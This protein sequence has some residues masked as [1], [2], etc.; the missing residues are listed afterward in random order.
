MLILLD[1]DINLDV[2]E[3]FLFEG[4]YGPEEQGK[5]DV[6]TLSRWTALDLLVEVPRLLGEKALIMGA[7]VDRDKGIWKL[8]GTLYRASIFRSNNLSAISYNSASTKDAITN[9]LKNKDYDR[10]GSPIAFVQCSDF[11]NEI[12]QKI[13]TP[14]AYLRLEQI[15]FINI[16]KTFQNPEELISSPAPPQTIEVINSLSFDENNV[17][18]LD[19]ST[20]GKTKVFESTCAFSN[21]GSGTILIGLNS[22]K[23]PIG[24]NIEEQQLSDFIAEL[25]AA[26]IPTPDLMIED[27]SFGKTKVL[28]I[29]VNKGNSNLYSYEEKI[30]IRLDNKTKIANPESISCLMENKISLK[31]KSILK[32][33]RKRL[34]RITELIANYTDGLEVMEQ[35]SFIENS[36][37]PLYKL[38]NKQQIKSVNT[39]NTGCFTATGNVIVLSRMRP[40][41][42]DV[43]ARFTPT[44]AIYP[45]ESIKELEPCPY[46]GEKILIT[47]GGAVFY[48]N[49][50]SIP[51]CVDTVNTHAFALELKPEYEGKI[52]AK[53]ITAYLKSTALL[54]YA[55]ECND[56][57]DLSIPEIFNQ[58]RIPINISLEDRLDVEQI[59]DNIIIAEEKFVNETTSLCKICGPKNR[60]LCNDPMRNHNE[61][62]NSLM[63]LID[64]KIHNILCLDTLTTNRI[65]KKSKFFLPYCLG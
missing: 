55:Y 65:Q 5:D 25:R 60:N 38:I 1:N 16:L 36:S 17:I 22:K 13:G 28:S 4:G 62:I 44:Q 30:F 18:I 9:V 49:D 57:I 48:L 39:K 12:S 32:V 33:N 47:P 21:S 40:R 50:N 51:I 53:F 42:Q 64:H 14:R 10:N 6:T 52:S 29:R 24:I 37:E 35:L 2:V 34:D 61:Y 7:H 23:Q 19:L 15:N 20:E 56:T 63:E 3:R 46:V 31:Y 27:Y 41:S 45:E 26:I 11:H 54:Y 58:I 8:P 59:V 43:V